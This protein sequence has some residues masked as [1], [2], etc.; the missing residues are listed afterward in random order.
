M[1]AVVAKPVEILS[2]GLMFSKAGDFGIL[3][4]SFIVV[5]FQLLRLL[6]EIELDVL[7]LARER[8]PHRNFLVPRVYQFPVRCPGAGERQH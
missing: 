5:I 7:T 1:T 8:T 6:I 4:H 2:L 3:V